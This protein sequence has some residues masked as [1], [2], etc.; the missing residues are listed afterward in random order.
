METV[1]ATQSGCVR[2]TTEVV[3]GHH[4]AAAVQSHPAETLHAPAGSCSEGGMR[5]A[6]GT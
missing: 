3:R 1:F 6:A 2:N 5:S 4:L